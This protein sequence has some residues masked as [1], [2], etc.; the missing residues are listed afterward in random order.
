ML[1]MFGCDDIDIPIL[2]A[3]AVK[4]FPD[5][6]FGERVKTIQTIKTWQPIYSYTGSS[7]SR[8]GDSGKR[9]PSQH[10][11]STQIKIRQPG[12]KPPARLNVYNGVVDLRKFRKL[13]PMASTLSRDFEDS[14]L[15]MDID[16]E[17]L[18]IDDTDAE[19]SLKQQ[20]GESESDIS[21]DEDARDDHEYERENLAKTPQKKLKSGN[22]EK[23]VIIHWLHKNSPAML[24]YRGVGSTIGP[25][26]KTSLDRNVDYTIDSLKSTLL[27]KYITPKNKKFFEKS[28][29]DIGIFNGDT[30]IYLLTVARDDELGTNDQKK[31]DTDEPRLSTPEIYTKN[32]ELF[33]KPYSAEDTSALGCTREESNHLVQSASRPS[34]IM[35]AQTRGAKIV[36]TLMIRLRE[37]KTNSDSVQMDAANDSWTHT[38]SGFISPDAEYVPPEIFQTKLPSEIRKRVDI[39]DK[40]IPSQSTSLSC[41]GLSLKGGKFELS[42]A[43]Q[44]S[45]SRSL[46]STV[47]SSALCHTQAYAVLKLS[48]HIISYYGFFYPQH[49]NLFYFE[50]DFKIPS[51]PKRSRIEPRGA[52]TTNIN[53]ENQESVNV[54]TTKNPRED[55][56]VLFPSSKINNV[57][58]SEREST[59]SSDEDLQPGDNTHKLLTEKMNSSVKLINLSELYISS[60]VIGSGGQ[61]IVRYDKF[62]F[63]V[64]AVKTIQNRNSKTSLKEILFLNQ[65]RHQNLINVLAVCDT[66]LSLHIVTELFESSD[67]AEI[68]FDPKTREK[69]NLCSSDRHC[70]AKQIFQGLVYL[71][72]EKS[73]KTLTPII[74]RDIKPANILVNTSCLVKICDLGFASSKS[75]E[76]EL[77]STRDDRLRGTFN[78]MAPEIVLNKQKVNSPHSDVWAYACTLYELYTETS[79]WLVND[80][81]L[82]EFQ[83]ISANL[84]AKKVPKVDHHRLPAFLRK[85]LAESFNYTPA[86]R[87]SMIDFVTLF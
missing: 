79:V 63:T 81:D 19:Y 44:I 48:Y 78:Y 20:D 18:Y 17:Y 38:E 11:N 40:S 14:K 56:N 42:S 51:I 37:R 67:L 46:L 27:E 75:L 68:L 74:H 26:V 65:I 15:F 77:K 21:S 35:N 83:Y 5:L 30:H 72:L 76:S 43:A 52:K 4:V 36:D 70:I 87:P 85:K 10:K 12:G 6:G 24:V 60:N 41:R 39:T 2:S 59:S 53:D 3:D 82:D 57:G 22:N 71:H 7:D 86:L 49:R 33:K 32:Q 9:P 13:F 45:S 31:S 66:F 55:Q 61:G 28:T 34:K 23:T 64:V 16:E 25:N 47:D 1:G 80:I 69:Y 73:G 58:G 84:M 29:V 62:R 50:D 54:L 8:L